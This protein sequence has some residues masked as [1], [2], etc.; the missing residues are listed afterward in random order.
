VKNNKYRNVFIKDLKTNNSVL[1]CGWLS[2]K[3]DHG[4]LLFLEIRDHTGLIQV[5]VNNPSH[6]LS[7]LSVESVLSIEGKIIEREES[8]INK[9]IIN[10]DIE[11]I[12]DKFKILS[13]AKQTPFAINDNN[14][15]DE[16]KQKYRTLYL[17]SHK[18]QQILKLRSKL[19]NFMRDFMVKRDFLEVSTPIITASSPEG[20]RDFLIP[21][22]LHP[23]KFYALPQAPQ[24]FK[25][26]LM[27]SGVYRYFQIAPCFRDEDA[28]KDRCYG[29][30]Y[31]LDFELSFTQQSEVLEI[32]TN[33]VKEIIIEF[34]NITPN[35]S[36]MKYEDALE[37][38][39]SDKPDLRIPLKLIDCTEILKNSE[40]D[41]F[42]RPIKEKDYIVKGIK[43]KIS[44]N[45]CNHLLEFSEKNGF[46]IAFIS[47]VDGA[48]KGPIAKFM[49]ENILE[50]GESFIFICDQAEKA[51]KNAGVLIKY[52]GEYLNLIDKNAY[53][54]IQITDFPMFEKDDASSTGW[55]FT[56]NPFSMPQTED[57]SDLS[58]VYAY[59]YDL[60]LNG[61]ELASGSVRNHN[62]DLLIELF[63]KCGYAP[64]VT[65]DK[66]N[67]MISA[68]QYGVPPH[69]GSAIGI[70]RLLMIL[71]DEENV[72]EVIA[73]P[74]NTNGYDP[75]T[76]TPSEIDAKTLKSLNIKVI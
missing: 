28:R 43:H 46:K 49:K 23:G 65:K 17:R 25:Q 61:Y 2:N 32:L 34:K 64:E 15:S 68:F 41:L 22:R 33:I 14:I 19:I 13:I 5:V 47:K 42:K 27:C 53:E 57:F 54:I 52:M 4:S 69:G 73:F 1:I 62:P 72:R 56:H 58:K 63:E 11:L 75:L 71:T 7:S 37:N 16:M 74:L 36:T 45:E 66:F 29:E 39:G 12:L 30:F 40:M 67:S 3:R 24:V 35:I 50:E 59:Q 6:E 8:Q 48:L 21:S 20:A 51:K 60:V 31:Q 9:H 38:Y 10:G 26:L 70:E 44:Y 18:M 76:R 55:S